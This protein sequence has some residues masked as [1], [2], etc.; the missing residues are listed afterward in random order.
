MCRTHHDLRHANGYE[1]LRGVSSVSAEYATMRDYCEHVARGLSGVVAMAAAINPPRGEAHYAWK[2]DDARDE[3]KRERC[4]KMYPLGPCSECQ[5][6][7]TERHHVDGDT[8]N[9]VA[10]NV[11][12]LCR[13]CHMR[14]DGRLEALKVMALANAQRMRTPP[15]A[16]VNCSRMAKPTRKGR[17]GACNEY[18]R[19]N[20]VERPVPHA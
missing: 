15:R 4:Q 1:A 10:A 12:I 6:Q 7:G 17:C 5:R 20:G 19:R 11:M 3:T 2:G 16:C 13:R 8:G 9:N 18:L 14:L